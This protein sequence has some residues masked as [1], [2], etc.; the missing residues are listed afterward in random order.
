MIIARFQLLPSQTLEDLLPEVESKLVALLP[1]DLGQDG[2]AA[3]KHGDLA[4]ALLADLGENL[5]PVGTA[6]V[7][8]RLQAGDQVPLFL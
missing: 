8:P 3:V 1:E 4:L 2:V 6:G 7:G 5:V